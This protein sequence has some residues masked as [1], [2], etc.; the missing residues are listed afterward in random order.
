ME[1][2]YIDYHAAFSPYLL[3][4]SDPDV[5]G[6][7]IQAIKEGKSLIGAGTTP[8]EGELANLLVE[9]IPYAGPSAD[10]QYRVRSDLFR[11]AGCSRNNRTRRSDYHAGRLQRLA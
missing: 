3:G 6:A 4:H 1:T 2:Q 7:V 11:R 5:D 9:C 8:W 10:H